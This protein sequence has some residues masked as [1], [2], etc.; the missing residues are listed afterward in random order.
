M[1]TVTTSDAKQAGGAKPKSWVLNQPLLE[2]KLPLL[3]VR[4]THVV[5]QYGWTD[6]LVF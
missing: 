4:H 5:C 2:R 1:T 6:Q 3:S